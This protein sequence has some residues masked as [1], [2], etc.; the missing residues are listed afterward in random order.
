ME[1]SSVLYHGIKKKSIVTV[2]KEEIDFFRTSRNA[3]IEERI[4]AVQ[5][6]QKLEPDSHG[7][8][9]FID[10]IMLRRKEVESEKVC[11]NCGAANDVQYNKGK[12]IPC[13]GQL[14]K[15]KADVQDIINGQYNIE[16]ARPYV[17][18]SELIETK[19]NNIVVKAGEPDFLN[20]NSYDNISQ[21]LRNLR[22]RA[23]I[24]KYGSG[25]RD[26]IILEADGM[27]FC[28][29]EQLIFNVPFCSSCKDSYYGE[30]SFKKHECYLLNRT[31]QP[32]YEF[33]W[34]VLMPGILH[35]EMNS[36][37]AFLG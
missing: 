19:K 5:K 34:V 16:N 7:Y 20:P 30:E 36:C 9:D 22:L 1:T 24:K 18:F 12:N 29:V 33:D 35:I 6:E 31:I 17:H 21:I 28:I 8:Y 23:G 11:I 10:K 4:H 27:I 25:E 3:F 2:S 15:R 37:K 14:V 26:W 32:Q 13:T